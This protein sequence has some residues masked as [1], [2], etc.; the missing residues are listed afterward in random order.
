MNKVVSVITIASIVVYV[1]ATPITIPRSV[2]NANIE[3][4]RMS[5]KKILVALRAF[6]YKYVIINFSIRRTVAVN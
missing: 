2:E 3:S 4:T 5:L 1:I 6:R